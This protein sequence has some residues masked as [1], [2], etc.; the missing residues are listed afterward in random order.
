MD[1][2]NPTD[3]WQLKF[4]DAAYVFGL[5][6]AELCRTNPWP[7]NFQPLDEAMAYLATEFWDHQFTQTEIAHA[8]E[9]AVKKLSHYVAGEERRS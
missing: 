6:V 1:P 9:S 8:F 3:A 4:Y 7:Q 5:S 2:N